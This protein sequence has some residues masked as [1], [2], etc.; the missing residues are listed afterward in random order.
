MPP[1]SKPGKD[2]KRPPAALDRCLAG[3]YI[4]SQNLRNLDIEQMRSVRGLV[5]FE[6]SSRDGIRGWGL[7]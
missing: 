4:A 5:C 7:Q 6:D 1:Y 2:V 3:P